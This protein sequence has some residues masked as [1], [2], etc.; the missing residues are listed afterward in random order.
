MNGRKFVLRLLKHLPSPFVQWLVRKPT[1]IDGYRL[2]PNLQLLAKAASRQSQP[3][4]NL[5]KYRAVTSKAFKLLNAPRRRRVQVNDQSFASPACEL[6]LR[7]YQPA[8]VSDL[9][10]A[11]L[12]F[13]QGGLVLMDL[14]TCDTFCTILAAECNARVISLDYR[15]CPEHPFPAPIDDATALWDHV[16]QHADS[17]GIDPNRVAVAGDGAGGLISAVLC[18]LLKSRGGVQPAGQLLIYPWVASV[19]ENRGSLVSCADTFPLSR[20]VMEYFMSLVFPDGCGAD[21]PLANPL[22]ASDVSGLPPAVVVTAGFDPLRDQG[23]AYAERLSAAGVPVVHHCFGSLC[24]GFVAMGN[25]AKQAEQASLQ[26]ARD[27]AR[28]L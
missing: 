3:F 18:Q 6:A 27:L 19:G 9:S 13:H 10:A 14:D 4:D 22:D 26:I 2:D 17:F 1:K 12:F 21:D 16:Q 7:F 5:G 8:G 20:E 23:N 11:I 24:H 15:R 28:L 25:V